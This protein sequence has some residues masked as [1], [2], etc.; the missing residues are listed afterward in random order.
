MPRDKDLKRIVRARMQK[1]G[2]AYTAARANVVGRSKDGSTAHDAAPTS[3]EMKP[4]SSETR[5]VDYASNAGRSDD[6][7]RAKTG[8]D[9]S[10]WVR[11]LDELNAATLEHG[12]IARL[13][14][15]Q[16]GVGRSYSTS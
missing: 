3:P 6:T 12:A 1:T 16:F 9:W 8:R 15:D 14:Q 4:T 5:D 10:G 11:A 7:V 13:V 2:E